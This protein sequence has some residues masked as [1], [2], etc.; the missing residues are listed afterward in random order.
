MKIER[1]N[2]N[3]IKVFLNRADLRE[4][5]IKLTELA[6]GSEKTQAFFREMMEQ[7]LEM[8][9]FEVEDEPV[10]IEAAPASADG[11]VII[12]SKISDENR[13]DERLSLLPPSKEEKRFKKEEIKKSFNRE[14]NYYD[15]SDDSNILIYTFDNM[16][17]LSAAAHGADSF[18]SGTNALYKYKNKYFLVLQNDNPL[19]NIETDRLDIVFS[20]YGYKHISNVISKYFLV[21]HGEVI[22][23]ENAVKIFASYM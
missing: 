5:N 6:Y 14:K 23:K 17:D 8:C 20:E 2:E 21:E 18:Y 15:D 4:R 12:V 3:Q 9:G 13:N 19:D 22:I 11:I 10:M 1:I 7:A 16:D